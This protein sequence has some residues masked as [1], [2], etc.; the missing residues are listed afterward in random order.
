MDEPPAN[1]LLVRLLDGI[2]QRPGRWRQPRQQSACAS[3]PGPRPRFGG[4]PL[5]SRVAGSA[6]PDPQSS[7]PRLPAPPPACASWR[8]AGARPQQ[9]WVC[10]SSCACAGGRG[11]CGG[12]GT[13]GVLRWPSPCASSR[14]ASS[15]DSVGVTLRV[16]L[17]NSGASLFSHPTPSNFSC[18]LTSILSLWNPCAHLHLL[19]GLCVCVS[20]PHHHHLVW[21]GLPAPVPIQSSDWTCFSPVTLLGLWS[22]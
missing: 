9:R 3:W 22:L 20:A 18:D 5:P 15:I 17:A 2:R 19:C 8:P 11:Q 13:R 16:P 1:I 6:P 21:P 10:P 4:G 7:S 12:Q 14:L